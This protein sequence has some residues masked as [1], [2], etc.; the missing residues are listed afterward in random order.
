MRV[1]TA[2]ILRGIVD[3]WIP[4]GCAGC[5]A[6]GD[7]PCRSCLDRLLPADSFPAPPG[8]DGVAALLRYDDGSRPFVAA[9]KYRGVRTV[10]SEFA[11]P[12]AA[13]VDEVL[14]GP[15]PP[16]VT[17]APTSAAR[18]RRRGYDQAEVLAR[19]IAR[20]AR[21]PVRSLLVRDG[22]SRQTGRDR[23]ARLTGVRF[24]P[25]GSVPEVV[26]VC[27]DVLTT[28][29]TLTA[30]AEALRSASPSVGVHGLVLA[31]TPSW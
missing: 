31:R 9:L 1:R 16:V 29:A 15:V 12:L 27:D 6:E 11:R 30:A 7:S 25:I 2:S 3:L 8:L 28:G 21:V 19:A 26:I 22:R 13:L 23:E 17:W 10:A 24:R 20:T 18:R 5:G 14:L 4:P